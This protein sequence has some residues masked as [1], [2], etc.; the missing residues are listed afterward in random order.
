[1]TKNELSKAA[2]YWLD[3]VTEFFTT[4]VLIKALKIDTYIKITELTSQDVKD[5]LEY[6]KTNKED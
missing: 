2:K 4:K 5:L 3:N 1:M 6:F